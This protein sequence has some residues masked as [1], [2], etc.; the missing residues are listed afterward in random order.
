MNNKLENILGTEAFRPLREKPMDNLGIYDFY[1]ACE[2]AVNSGEFEELYVT[3]VAETDIGHNVG[4][5]VLQLVD[6]K[7]SWLTDRYLAIKH[8][9]KNDDDTPTVLAGSRINPFCN[10]MSH[11]GKS[12]DQG[13][14]AEIVQTDKPDYLGTPMGVVYK[15]K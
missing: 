3:S 10:P 2:M 8:P 4:F 5:R 6:K 1:K 12:W 14:V 7:P 9:G 13:I 11:D 15:L